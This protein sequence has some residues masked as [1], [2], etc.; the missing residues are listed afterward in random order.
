MVVQLPARL[1]HIYLNVGICL[2]IL[3]SVD[4]QDYPQ[5]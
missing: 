1:I 3:Q 2:L 4:Q 5:G